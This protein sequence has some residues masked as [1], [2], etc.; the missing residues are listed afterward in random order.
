MGG[1]TDRARTPGYGSGAG[2][3]FDDFV[4]SVAVNVTAETPIDAGGEFGRLYAL[5]V[6]AGAT[7]NTAVPTGLLES[8]D[9]WGELYEWIDV[10]NRNVEA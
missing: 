10:C 5:C 8:I 3:S 4:A 7:R 2:V 9:T 1:Q 6:F